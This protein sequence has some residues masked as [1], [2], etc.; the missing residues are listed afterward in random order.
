MLSYLIS[1]QKKQ[2]QDEA[3]CLHKLEGKRLPSLIVLLL[4]NSV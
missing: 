4:L 3:V 1:P 2:M